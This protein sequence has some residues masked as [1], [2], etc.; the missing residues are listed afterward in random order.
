L[1]L[2]SETKRILDFDIE[3]MPVTYYRKDYP[4]A[5]ITAIAWA[6]TDKPKDIEVRV[7]E[8]IRDLDFNSTMLADFW[9]AYEE[10]DMVAGHYIRKHD[11]PIINGQIIEA[12]F[13]EGLSPKLTSDTMLDLVKFSNIPKSQEFLEATMGTATQKFNMTQA[14]WRKANRFTPDGVAKTRT[15]VTSDVKGNMQLRK[16]LI[17]RGLLKEPR[18]WRP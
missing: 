18:M 14:D 11:L 13:A 7:V 4:T 9:D 5:I 6:F 8:D 2:S 16:E 12:G 1:P 17:S 15:R 10:A 3:N